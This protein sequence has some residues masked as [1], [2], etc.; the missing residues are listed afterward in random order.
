M[1]IGG[2]DKREEARKLKV[3]EI[4]KRKEERAQKKKVQEKKEVDRKTIVKKVIS[5][6]NEDE[7]DDDNEA[8]DQD[9]KCEKK[10]KR[11][12][13]SQAEV[14]ELRVVFEEAERWNLTE[15]GTA[16]MV[17]IMNA[18]VGK[19]TKENQTFVLT[20]SRVHKVKNRLRREKVAER[21][22]KSPLAAGVDER[23]DVT[24]K[25]AGEGLK[26]SRRYIMGREEH[27]SVIFW[28]GETY[29][30]HVVPSAGTGRG[31]AVSFRDFL[32]VRETDLT[33]LRALLGDGC[34]KVTGCWTGFMAELE[35]LVSQELGEVRPLQHIVCLLHHVEKLFE[36]IFYYHDGVT[37]GPAEFTGPIGKQLTERR[38]HTRPI[39]KFQ[40]FNN[41]EL[42][43][44]IQTLPHN[45]FAS[46]NPDHKML[47]K[48]LEG[49]LTGEISK[50]WAE[51]AI[52]Q[53]CSSRY[54][55]NLLVFL[56]I[57]IIN[58]SF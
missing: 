43:L 23:I 11:K 44:L 33:R 24:K 47:I 58:S 45:V 16:S 8:K 1:E 57:F 20:P 35:R 17:N 12:R 54:I 19:I 21:K 3:A 27:A 48:L 13:Y 55:H 18:K 34:S 4:E 36:K 39:V 56:P 38:V 49:L 29:E 14:E 2:V 37:A 6:E 32:V 25:L 46:L 30:G 22:G 7:T 31:L 52:G 28:P 53:V 15:Q 42:L 10:I 50:Q 41:P 5:K 26:G 51:M 9:Y 40:P